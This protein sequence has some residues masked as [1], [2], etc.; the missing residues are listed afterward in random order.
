MSTVRLK[1][2]PLLNDQMLRTERLCVQCAIEGNATPA[3]KTFSSDVASV[4]MLRAEGQTAAV[5]AV[6]SLTWTTPD[7]NNAGS[8]VFGLYL[9]IGSTVTPSLGPVPTSENFADKVYKVEVIDAAGTATSLAVTGPNGVA[10][11][12][13]T[14]LGNIAIEIAATGLNLSSED[15]TLNVLVDYREM[16]K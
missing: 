16:S 3:D 9:N 7:D 5:D 1:V 14:P 10:N 11:A 12:F 4:V 15:A 8:S 2:K 6:E 13:L